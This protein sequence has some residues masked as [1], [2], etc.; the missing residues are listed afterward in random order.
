MEHPQKSIRVL[1]RLLTRHQ[2]NL[3]GWLH[4]IHVHDSI[5]E[6]FF[7]WLS[8]AMEF[9]NEGL[10]QPILVSE[11]IPPEDLEQLSDE[12]EEIVQWEET[13]RKR[14]Y[15]HL[16]R[17]YSADVDGDDPVI[18]EGDGFGRS[19]VEPLVDSK[20]VP[21][22]LDHIASCLE[23]FRRAVGKTLPP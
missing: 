6:D 21:P 11:I 22:Q 23:L 12:L 19:K 17:R 13:K 15:E 10:I 7:Q 5:I 1:A 2:N 8:T 9:L 20:P 14:Q 16:C 4:Q 3:Y 18:V